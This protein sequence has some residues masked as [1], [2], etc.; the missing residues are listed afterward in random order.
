MSENN[1]Q[2]Y[3]Q[4]MKVASQKIADLQSEIERLKQKEREPIAIVG[5]SCRLAEA[6]NP[7]AFWDL[8]ANGVDAIREAP[9]GHHSYLDPYYDPD[10]DVPGK[11]YIRRAG[12]LNQS[13]TDFDASFFGISARE[14]ASLDPQHRLV[15]EVAWEALENA[16]FVPE[17]L[18]G[19]QTG[20]F[21]GICANDYVWQLVKQD[22]VETDFYI[23]SGNAYSPVAGR[24]SY[25]FDFTGPCLAVDTGCASSLAAIHLAVTN[26]RRGD[27]NL[28]L[29]GGV[30]RYVSPEYWLNLCKSRMLSP[31]GRCKTFAAGAN[32]Y[33]RGEGCGI[34][35]L[36][37]LSDAVAD[38]DN[39][40][41]L[42]RGTAHGQDGRTSGLTVP[43]GSSQQNVIR[44]AIANAGIKPKDVNYIEAHGTGTS[45]G[46][47]IEANA[48][49]KVFRQREEP[50]ILGSA[51][52]N[53]GHLEGAAGVAGLIKIVLSLQNELIP[54]H[55]H[56][57]EPSPYIA[58]DEMPIKV[59]S[60]QIPWPATDKT[61]FA[62]VSSFGFTGI[63]VHA[64][65]SE[66]PPVAAK[67]EA[68]TWQRPLQLLTL[69][70]KTKPAL[71][72]MVRNYEK[73]LATHPDLEWADIC[74]TTNTR[75]T[76]FH[77][78]LAVV[79][80]SVSQA[81]EKLLANLAGTE[82][83][84]LFKGSKSESQ[85]QIA[86]LFTGQGS[87]YLGM[88]RELYETQPIFR[89]ALDRCQEILNAI[90]NQEKSLLSVLYQGDDSSVLEQTAYTQPALFALEYALASMWKS[91]GLEPSA[92]IGHSV[93]EYAAACVA[94]I[95][96]LE[97]G[98]KLIAARG[99]LMQK[100][101]DNGEMVSLLASVEQV[102]EAIKGTDLV[103]IA[104]INGPESVVISGEREA[105]RLVVQKLEHKGIKT[106]RLKVSHA[107]HSALMK[108]MLAEFRQVV[109]EVTFH[110]PKLNFISNVTGNFERV[111]P[112]DP[113]YWVDHVV[114]PVRFADG[115]ETLHRE[116]VEI[117]VEMGPQPILLGMARHCLPSEYGTWL[118]TLQ[119]EQSDWQGVLQAVG[120]LY[121]RGVAIDWEGFHRDYGYRQVGVPTYPWQRERYWIDVTHT[122]PLTQSGSQSVAHSLLGQPSPQQATGKD[123]ADQVVWK[124]QPRYG[125]PADYLA[126]PSELTRNIDSQV[127]L[128]EAECSRDRDQEKELESR[129]VGYIVSAFQQLGFKFEP[130]LHFSTAELI[131]Q[132]GIVKQHQRLIGC[133][134]E[135]MAEE[136]LLRFNQSEWQVVKTPQIVTPDAQV[137]NSL[138]KSPHS[139]MAQIVSRCGPRLADVLQGKYDPLQLLF[140]EGDLTS[141]T[142][143]YQ[144]SP[145]LKFINTLAQQV[146]QAAVSRLPQD[147]G[148]RILEIG[149]G[150]GATTS[151]LLPNLPADRV[152]YLFT[153]IGAFFV[154]R[155]QE[156]FA[157]YS[158]VR[159]Q[160]LDIEQEP[161]AVAR[162]YYD[163]IIAP[164]VLHATKDLRETVKNV[165]QMLA[166][167]GM[168]MLVESTTRQPSVDITFGLTEGWWRFTD[169][170]LRPDYPLLSINKWQELLSS[171]GF[172]NPVSFSSP[173]S[174]KVLILAQVTKEDQPLSRNWL[175]F[176]DNHGFAQKLAT[177]MKT[178]G[179]LPTVVFPNE[180]LDPSGTETASPLAKYQ[181]LITDQKWHGVVHLGNLDSPANELDVNLVKSF[182]KSGSSPRFWLVTQ[183]VQAIEAAQTDLVRSH[184]WEISQVIQSEPDHPELSFVL[185]NLAPEGVDNRVQTILDEIWIEPAS[186]VKLVAF[187]DKERLVAQLVN[188]EKSGTEGI[189][190]QKGREE[191]SLNLV[192]QLKA[193]EKEQR[194]ALLIAHIQSLLSQ[195]LGD[196]QERTFSLS[197]GFLD[198][199]MD[200]MTSIE[201][202][203]RLQ[204]SIGIPLSSTLF[205]KYPTPEALVDYLIQDVLA[206]F[207][208]FDD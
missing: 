44:R 77:E 11:V 137:A 30:Q 160:T 14:A 22:P 10:P 24:L 38:G 50:L 131:E 2:R 153:D 106:K 190:K 196:K 13:P 142:E 45:L 170:D 40:L 206:T 197:Q 20:V 125:L 80:D 129:S 51:K 199:G 98:L 32:G 16:G 60:E 92:V 86:F 53:I 149:A 104:A 132:L 33:A 101:P 63:N 201:L 135:I 54:Q 152:E 49:I 107:F 181:D 59:A 42:I 155:A 85:P 76:H 204:N 191:T 188:P 36:K 3:V 194:K 62:G 167:G 189:L 35:V 168:L 52:T 185:L 163:L 203:N 182:V 145:E 195:V 157:D 122:Q 138:L 29:A 69:S 148:M 71:E 111:L 82:N 121:V 179:D 73:H 74:Y 97:D 127:L 162:G 159:Y 166:P 5:M 133:F 9:K 34:I 146:V 207:V 19:S 91:W 150:T 39:I 64:V 147:R 75:R 31:D 176:A 66:A 65:L 178:K 89:Q 70:A 151:Y 99:Q 67:S 173:N 143:L 130:N 7:E 55:L 58:W 128:S 134:L 154:A 103:S 139:A 192:E 100:L 115:V 26:L 94:G 183:G 78:R 158:F 193:T 96:S 81:Q 48:L 177:E 83:T 113:E 102:T 12:F 61:R 1:E 72:Q 8:L 87:Q 120:Q 126:S 4:L 95:F 202:R 25:F 79:A 17:K 205:Y 123:F 186:S 68:K 21:M 184:L 18:A 105:V 118:P 15:M 43:S 187:R 6:D 114:K 46:D 110:Q 88:G 172:T 84:N 117:F 180:S 165:Q 57:Q 56:F 171:S 175:I 198:L 28:A 119:R 141:T 47:P 37:R 23:G 124:P 93:G 108:P 112:T 161:V 109:Q 41:A 90:G 208:K 169:L 140:P 136:G 164:N 27:C 144:D 116:G 174:Q 200:S 156:K